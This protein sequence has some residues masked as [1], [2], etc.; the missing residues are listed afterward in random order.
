MMKLKSLI[1]PQRTISRASIN[2]VPVPPSIQAA[3]L[4]QGAMDNFDHEENTKSGTEGSQDKFSC[5][6]RMEKIM[7]QI[8]STK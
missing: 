1:V 7:W 6:F 5:C 8:V 3:V 2:H 4:I